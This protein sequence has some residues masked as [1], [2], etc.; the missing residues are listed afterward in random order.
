MATSANQS[1]I[2]TLHRLYV[3]ELTLRLKA[4]DASGSVLATIGNFLAKSGTKATNDSPAMQRLA[5]TYEA[6]PFMSDDTPSLPTHP[7]K[8][9]H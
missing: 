9:Q 8:D 7:Q 1:A 6:L 3:A 5:A 2:D 4:G